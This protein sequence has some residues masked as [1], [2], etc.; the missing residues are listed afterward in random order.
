MY[1]SEKILPDYSEKEK[2]VTKGWLGN[3]KMK[4]ICNISVL[5]SFV[6]KS[7][8]RIARRKGTATTRMN[9]LYF[10][11]LKLKNNIKIYNLTTSMRLQVYNKYQNQRNEQQVMAE[12]YITILFDQF[13]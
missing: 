8:K 11:C 13:I 9:G 10:T 4:K 1:I 5:T 12:D 2:D 7:G 3:F 6:W